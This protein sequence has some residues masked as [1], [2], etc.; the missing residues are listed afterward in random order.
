MNLRFA[1]I[2]FMS[3]EYHEALALRT[4]I[5]RKPLNMVYYPEDLAKEFDSVHL[6]GFLNDEIVGTLIL[7]PIA[8]QVYKM[9]QVA[10]SEAMQGTGIGRQLVNF[11]EKWALQN[12]HTEMV[13]HARLSAVP[14]YKK[15]NYE[16]LGD[17]FF[18]VGIPHYKMKKNLTT[19]P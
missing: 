17:E 4:D 19:A 3:P 9:R 14:F 11:A 18:E 1:V 7:Q 16:T 10:V 5:L 13:L 15:L 12:K 8:D 6:A 2:D